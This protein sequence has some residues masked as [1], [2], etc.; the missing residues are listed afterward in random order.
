M[1]YLLVKRSYVFTS[2]NMSTSPIGRR[3]SFMFYGET[4]QALAV[5]EKDLKK[6]GVEADWT[7]ILRAIEPAVS[8]KEILGHGILRDAFE[9]SADAAG[10]DESHVVPFR[11]NPDHFDKLERVAN[12]AKQIDI[13]LTVGVLI[14]ALAVSKPTIEKLAAQVRALYERFPD[15]RALRWQK[16]R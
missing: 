4:K 1:F 11:M 7:D 3:T 6:A 2:D 8:E 13:L 12:R 15:G 16:R 10:L 5:L 9:R 14:R